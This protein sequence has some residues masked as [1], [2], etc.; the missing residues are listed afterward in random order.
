[1]DDCKLLPVTARNFQILSAHR[2]NGG[3]GQSPTYYDALDLY[4]TKVAAYIDS[5]D[6]NVSVAKRRGGRGSPRNMILNF[7]GRSKKPPSNTRPP[8]TSR[9]KA[10]PGKWNRSKR[11][12]GAGTLNADVT[13]RFFTSRSKAAA[14]TR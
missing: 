7:G 11:T 9:K 2:V 6:A 8:I 12:R 3:F 10:V 4:R 1:M 5:V 14:G 13:T